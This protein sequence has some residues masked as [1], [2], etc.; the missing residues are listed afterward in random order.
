MDADH[1]CGDGACAALPERWGGTALQPTPHVL[2][3]LRCQLGRKHGAH[4]GASYARA[5]LEPEP[6][7][8]LASAAERRSA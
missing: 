3:F 6:A 2:G 5:L 1:H 4:Q 8:F 7:G